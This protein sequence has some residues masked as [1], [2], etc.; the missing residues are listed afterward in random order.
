MSQDGQEIKRDFI[1][2]GPEHDLQ[3]GS[4]DTPKIGL[5]HWGAEP[6]EYDRAK[7]IT[8]EFGSQFSTRRS[9]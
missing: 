3:R 8:P 5:I 1:K 2:F 9:P 7:A 4:R 6:Y